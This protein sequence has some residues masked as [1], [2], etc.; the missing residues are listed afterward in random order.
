MRCL[1]CRYCMAACP[2]HARSF[3]WWDPDWPGRLTETLNPEVSTRT[4]GVVEKCTFCSHRLQ[5]AQDA[6]AAAGG[7]DEAPRVHAGLR[8]GLPG[9]GD[10]LR[11]P[12]RPGERGRPPRPR[13]R[14][15]PPPR[16]AGD[17]GEGLLPHRAR[18]GAAPG[19]RPHR[20]GRREDPWMNDSCR[21]ASPARPSRR[22]L[23]WL[24]A[25]GGAPR[26]RPLR[27]VPL[28][29]GRPQ[30]DEHGQP[31]RLRALDL[32]GPDGHR[33]R[34]GGVLH[35]LPPLRDEEARA[36]GGHQQRGRHRLHLL[37]GGGR[38]PRD[39]RGPAPAVLVHVLAPERPLD[40]DRGHLLP[41]LLP[42]RAGD[43]VP[44]PRPQEPAAPEAPLDAPLRVRAAQGDGRLR[45]RGH[46][47]VVLPPGLAGR[48]LRRPPGT[49][50]RLPRVARR[51]ALDLLPLH[52][53][54][55]R[56]G[57]ELRP[58]HHLDRVEGLGAAAREAR[59]LRP[60]RPR[61]RVAPRRLRPRQERGHPRLDQP[62]VLPARRPPRALLRLR[63][64]RDVGAL[65]R[66]RPPR[67][68]PRA[69]PRCCRGRGA[70]PGSSSP[71]PSWPARASP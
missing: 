23:L 30:P 39:R 33:A 51:L 8:R 10:R 65:R 6:Q 37:L 66:D 26:R 63:P 22:F 2:Y 12:G 38:H 18:L 36:R 20:G 49:A 48:A 70:T 53:L 59:G 28:P 4:R 1:G 54:R 60:P 24:R 9:G 52:P 19:R 31:L 55:R 69:P 5:A 35:R 15:L 44:A 62:H 3:N 27:R 57:A 45:P 50:L 34:G 13:A 68:R 46:V 29:R 64:L 67:P 47:P 61:L 16:A 25:L 32:P 42:H 58:R 11:R 21:A 14:L 17:G 43:R 56:G 41:H 7:E 71:R 40:A